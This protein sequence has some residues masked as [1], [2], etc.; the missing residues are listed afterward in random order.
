MTDNVSVEFGAQTESLEAGGDRVKSKLKEIGGEVQHAEELFKYLAERMVEV[1]ALHEIAEFVSK[2]SELGEEALRASAMLGMTVE[3]V[4]ELSYAAKLA[5]TDS[6]SFN[7]SMVRFERNI[8][9]AEKG[10]GKAAEAFHNLGISQQEL[11]N[12]SPAQLLYQVADAFAGTADG[13][14]KVQYAIALGGRSWAQMIPMLDRGGDALRKAAEDAKDTGSVMSTQLAEALEQTHQGLVRLEASWRGTGLAI[15][16]VLGPAIDD[17]IAGLTVLDQMITGSIHIL[18]ELQV[19]ISAELVI[20]AARF[21]EAV[22]DLGAEVSMV[23]DKM[24]IRWNELGA[25]MIAVATGEWDSLSAIYDE[26]DAKS[27]QATQKAVTAIQ[28]QEKAYDELKSSALAAMNTMLAKQHEL[29]T[30]ESKKPKLSPL[31]GGFGKQ[32]NTERQLAEE[33]IRFKEQMGKL[34]IANRK[35]VL[36]EK[37]A[38]GEISKKQE[39]EQLQQL[40]QDEY[41]TEWKALVDATQVDGLTIVE[42]QKLYDQLALLH[43]KYINQKETLTRKSL[44]DEKKQYDQVFQGINRAFSGSINGIIQGTQTWQQATSHLFTSILASFADMAEKMVA[45]WLESL[46]MQA[47]FGKTEGAGQI[48]TSAAEAGAAAFASTAAIPIIGPELAPASAASAYASTMAFQGALPSFAVGVWDVP[49]DMVAQIHK[50]ETIVPATYAEGMRNNG[51]GG[52][53]DTFNIAIHATDAQSVANL[54]KQNGAA[55]AQ[56]L[57][58]QI[59]NQSGPLS[60][61]LRTSN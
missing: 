22:Q 11:K 60:K 19:V 31:D 52:G 26:A 7:Q 23:I 2:M 13:A 40:A 36:D 15:M 44:D 29:E 51:G 25:T 5:G 43:D 54:F 56:V 37:V 61:S 33:D 41:N 45:K 4:Q 24:I 20:A 10:S 57:A 28:Q 38:L 58:G 47:V 39:N 48:A 21:L 14:E 49:H 12:S 17:L 18:R 50:G 6:E 46:L 32:D 59:R 9:D 34:E 1:F 3:Q 42:K 35:T 16:D 27:A 55:L 30:Q 8:A 53:G